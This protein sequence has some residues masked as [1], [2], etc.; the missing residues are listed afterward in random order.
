M[1]SL[2]NVPWIWEF[3]GGPKSWTRVSHLGSSGPAPYGSTK[4]SQVTQHRKQNPKSNGKSNTQ[5]PRAP[6]ET[7]I[8]TKEKGKTERIKT[9]VKRE[10]AN[11]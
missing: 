2:I 5:Q 10:Q 6:K 7:H 9:G 1:F 11:Q 8:L 3:S 4:T